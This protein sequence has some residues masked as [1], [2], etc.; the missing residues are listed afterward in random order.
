MDRSSLIIQENDDNVDYVEKAQTAD[1][2]T[3][4]HYSRYG[5]F[6]TLLLAVCGTIYATCAI[7]T[8]T[9]S[10]VLPSAECDFNLSS[11]DK[12]KLSAMPLIGMIFGCSL[13]GS[14]ADS[15]GRKVAIMSS[16]LV[17][18][19]AAFI[20]SF[21]QSFQLFLICRFFNG[22]GIIGA[23]SIIFSYLGEFA[24]KKHRDVML[25]RLEVFWN[26]GVIF[27]PGKC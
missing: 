7:S 8:T 22:F 2:E 14:I 20:S 23:T 1:F 17:D 18:F 5:K 16:L 21:A 11:I 12:G 3:A 24:S 26:I 9:L 27:L 4:I 10:F 13:W 25:G 19:L 6:Q 15:K